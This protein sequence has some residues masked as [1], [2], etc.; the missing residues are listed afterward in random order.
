MVNAR[1]A[2]EIRLLP[3][4]ASD[5]RLFR[6]PYPD[7][8]T[9]KSP[10]IASNLRGRLVRGDICFWADSA[11]RP[12]GGNGRDSEHTRSRPVGA[13]TDR[14]RSPLLSLRQPRLSQPLHDPLPFTDKLR[15]GVVLHHPVILHARLRPA[16][17]KLGDGVGGVCRPPEPSVGGGELVVGPERCRIACGRSLAPVDRLLPL[18]EMRVRIAGEPLPDVQGRI[19]A[20]RAAAPCR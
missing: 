15:V 9:G 10:A 3:R 20:D 4:R 1:S 2:S 5:W 7:S 14:S 17:A 13:E 12:N 19:S 11:R 16:L 18:G 8:M 6:C